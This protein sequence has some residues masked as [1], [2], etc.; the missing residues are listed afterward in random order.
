M[1]EKEFDYMNVIPFV[2]IMLVLLTIVLMSSTFVASGV[3]PLEL[4][5]A[6]QNESGEV[7]SQI[8]E[9]DR[10]SKI[11]F[12]SNPVTIHTLKESIDKIDRATSILIRADKNIAL[13]VFVEILDLVKSN[14]FGKIQLQTETGNL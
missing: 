14:G 4:P 1:D 2:D 6:S 10:Q 9:I 8:I 11:F 13:E 5:R 12:N 7:R 3:I